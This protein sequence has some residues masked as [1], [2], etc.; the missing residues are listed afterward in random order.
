MGYLLTLIF[1]SVAL[2]ECPAVIT[3]VI[4][5]VQDTDS[6]AALLGKDSISPVELKAFKEAKIA[7]IVGAARTIIGAPMLI[8]ISWMFGHRRKK[9]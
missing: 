7:E 5:A 4:H 9:S 2:W 8:F 1:L 3:A 6:T